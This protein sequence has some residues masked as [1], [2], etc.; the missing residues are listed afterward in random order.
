M[1]RD[2]ELLTLML[3]DPCLTADE[4]AREAAA[5]AHTATVASE[6]RSKPVARRREARD[7]SREHAADG[8]AVG[9]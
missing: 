2:L 4:A 9:F 1:I 6:L 8:P 3:L 5:R 7:P